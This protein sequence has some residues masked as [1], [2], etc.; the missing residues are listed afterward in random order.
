MA[1]RSTST[2]PTFVE[3][4]YFNF[5]GSGR[6]TVTDALKS[7]YTVIPN[8]GGL[9]ALSF[10]LDKRT[11]KEPSTP[12]LTRLAELVL[13]MNLNAFSFNDQHYHQIGGV[14][15]GSKMG[16]NY[17]CLFVGYI[18]EQIRTNYT[19]FVPQL[20]KRYID[21]VVGAAQCSR[22]DL[23]EFINY[24]SNYHPALQFTS[25]ISELELPFLDIKL[26]IK[27]NTLQTS[28][29]YKET[30]THNYLHHTSLHPDHCKKAIPYSQFL[31]LRRICSDNDD[32][33]A[34]TSEMKTFFLARGYPEASLDN[35]LRRV[36]TVRRDDALTPPSHRDDNA[37]NRVPLVLTYNPFNTG[38]KRILLDNFDILSTDP[39][40]RRI[41]TEFPLVSYRSDKN[42][43]DALVHSPGY[44][45]S[46]AG[47]YPCRRPR[48][49]TCKYTTPQ[50]NVQGPKSVYTIRDR[51]TCQS[52]NVVYCIVCRR[53]SV[54]YIGETGRRLRERFSE[55]LR[56]IRNHSPGF[57]VAENF[58]SASHSLNDIA[59]CGLKQCSGGNTRRK[60]QEMRLIF[61]LGSLRPSGLNINFSFI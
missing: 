36:S 52:E 61:E 50:T 23:E 28:V 33:V 6:L 18:E 25:N 31:R 12:T 57:P 60:Q 5:H 20:H 4:G 44:T 41:F 15:M 39:E 58:N 48:C 55:H 27:N 24:V 38:T 45:H 14:A 51:F 34:R 53:C 1:I 59:V 11:V 17:A 49:L 26:A 37:E 10:F 2:T 7:L 47:T 22:L 40:T 32:F 3:I 29:H 9:E 21:D 16:S 43:R 19:G 30:D 35:D 56:S 46:V 42:L 13:I 54:L 8:H